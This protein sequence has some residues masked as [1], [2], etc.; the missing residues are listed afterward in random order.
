MGPSGSLARSVRSRD[1]LAGGGRHTACLRPVPPSAGG[2]PPRRSRR[3]SRAGNRQGLQSRDVSKEGGALG[4]EAPRREDGAQ[5]PLGP[6]SLG[7]LFLPSPQVVPFPRSPGARC[8]SPASGFLLS[9][10]R[11]L[12][13]PLL[14]FPEAGSSSPGRERATAACGCCS[15]EKSEQLNRKIWIKKLEFNTHAPHL[16]KH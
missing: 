4:Q 7:P 3:S 10:R 5:G 16:L 2:T 9:G 6:S 15:N 11:A 1:V 12:C 13:A 8:P 14:G